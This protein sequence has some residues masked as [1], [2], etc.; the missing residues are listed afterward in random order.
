MHG[1]ILIILVLLVLGVAAFFTDSLEFVFAASD[2]VEAGWD[3]A[4]WSQRDTAR[5]HPFSHYRASYRESLAALQV[6]LR[7]GQSLSIL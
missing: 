7:T 4:E 1:D 2:L 6:A 5:T 3:I